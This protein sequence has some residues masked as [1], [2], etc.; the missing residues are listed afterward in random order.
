MMATRAA[1]DRV[2]PGL[3]SGARLTGR[4]FGRSEV[5]LARTTNQDTLLVDSRA[6]LFAVCDGM[7]GCAG[8]KT[9]STLAIAAIDRSIS[10]HCDVRPRSGDHWSDDDDLEAA[11]AYAVHRASRDV[12][13]MACSDRSL[14]G[15]GTTATV[16]LLGET[17][18]AVAH[19]GDSRLYLLR[20]GSGSQLTRDHT[21]VADLVRAGDLAPE[22]AASHPRRHLLTRSVGTRAAVE[23]DSMV[24]DLRVGDRLV[25]CSDGMSAAIPSLG[26]LADRSAGCRIQD[27]P[28]QLVTAA[29]EAAVPDDVTVVAVEVEAATP[30]LRRRLRL[31]SL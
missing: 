5:G 7:G 2:G 25:L 19:V 23:V 1:G 26:W 31:A 6:G 16:L 12:F 4:G 30:P 14:A 28:S 8:G 18:G 17:Q 29:F 9:A 15:M 13:D 11:V 22:Q 24:V 27:L 3:G 10:R 20:N 21:L